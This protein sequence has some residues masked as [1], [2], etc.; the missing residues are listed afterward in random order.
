MSNHNATGVLKR[1]FDEIDDSFSPSS[2]KM[3]KHFHKMIENDK[4]N[5]K[6]KNVHY[7]KDTKEAIDNYYKNKNVLK[8]YINIEKEN[9]YYFNIMDNNK[10]NLV[11]HEYIGDNIS[12]IKDHSAV[13][14]YAGSYL[15]SYKSLLD[16]ESL[17]LF[18]VLMDKD[19]EREDLSKKLSKIAAYDTE[20]LNKALLKIVEEVSLSANSI[21]KRIEEEDLNATVLENKNNILT[22][23]IGDYDASEKLGSSQWCI[24]YNES[25]YEGYLDSTKD[26]YDRMTERYED[27][28]ERYRIVDDALEENVLPGNHVFVWDFNK[29]EN[30]PNYKIAFTVSSAGDVVAAHDQD[31][32]CIL[33]NFD[34]RTIHSEECSYIAQD[35]YNYFMDRYKSEGLDNWYHIYAKPFDVISNVAYPLSFYKHITE[36]LDITSIEPEDN[37]FLLPEELLTKTLDDHKLFNFRKV[38][39]VL[40]DVLWFSE[41]IA[42]FKKLAPIDVEPD[43]DGYFYPGEDGSFPFMC[44]FD[45]AQEVLKKGEFFEMIKSIPTSSA[46]LF[47]KKEDNRKRIISALEEDIKTVKNKDIIDILNTNRVLTFHN[48]YKKEEDKFDFLSKNSDIFGLSNDEK[49]YSIMASLKKDEEIEKFKENHICNEIKTGRLHPN[50]ILRNI[51]RINDCSLPKILNEVSKLNKSGVE[52]NLTALEIMEMSKSKDFISNIDEKT[53]I[54]IKKS[55][56]QDQSTFGTFKSKGNNNKIFFED[57]SFGEKMNSLYRVGIIDEESFLNNFKKGELC[58][59]DK[60]SFPKNDFKSLEDY[61]FSGDCVHIKKKKQLKLKL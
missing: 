10:T 12:K 20:D 39:D 22:V 38:E 53:A 6:I 42:D 59:G 61:I 27:N 3:K 2:S 54:L 25:N 26:E 17:S 40:E 23:M 18:K 24:S 9:N 15:R 13:K 51:H 16:D 57:F 11:W 5:N 21:I 19:L 7:I 32:E 48:S 1:I 43:E 45:D 30:D 4:N 60:D 46:H 14:K 50:H 56:G 41:F 55:I 37:G 29:T 35:G 34:N 8:Q 58:F 31:D 36:N 28:D 52:F 49:T 33:E 44:Y 47:F